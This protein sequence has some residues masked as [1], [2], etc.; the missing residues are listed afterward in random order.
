MLRKL[1]SVLVGV[2]LGMMTTKAVHSFS[3]RIHPAP[4][5]SDLLSEESFRAYMEGLP[6][7]VYYL[8]IIYF[9]YLY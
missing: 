3:A 2:V 6:A 9:T 5:S 7:E 8:I 4:S 1:L